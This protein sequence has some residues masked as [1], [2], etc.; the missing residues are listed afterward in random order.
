MTFV[1]QLCGS[2]VHTFT[3][4]Y[5]VDTAMSADSSFGRKVLQKVVGV[6]VMLSPDPP[7]RKLLRYVSYM[8]NV[9]PFLFPENTRNS[10]HGHLLFWDEE[11]RGIQ[12]TTSRLSRS[13]L[14]TCRKFLEY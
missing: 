11:G 3:K 9:P 7:L 4:F 14:V 6:E 12:P 8:T 1:G 2:S 13:F 10:L 5:K